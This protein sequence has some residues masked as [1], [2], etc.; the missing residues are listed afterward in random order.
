MKK[1]PKD[2]FAKEW[3]P[4]DTVDAIGVAVLDKIVNQGCKY[5]L[6]KVRKDGKYDV[7]GLVP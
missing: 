2:Q 6:I 3:Q 7:S 1:H 5:V 4:K